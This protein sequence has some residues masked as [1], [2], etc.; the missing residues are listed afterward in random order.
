MIY[1]I[2]QSIMQMQISQIKTISFVLKHKW[3]GMKRYSF[4]SNFILCICFIY[5][6]FTCEHNLLDS[7]RLSRIGEPLLFFL[8]WFL[9]L[10]FH[11]IYQ[12]CS[13][14]TA[15]RISDGYAIISDLS[16]LF[17]FVLI[18]GF[19][20]GHRFHIIWTN[21]ICSVALFFNLSREREGKQNQ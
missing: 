15:L 19:H 21:F 1:H 5:F 4:D 11:A 20:F 18:L 6:P 3:L 14:R 8:F 12:I 13:I 2:V 7:N 10:F 17:E 16:D 9:N